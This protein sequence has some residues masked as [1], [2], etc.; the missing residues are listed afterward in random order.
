MFLG[1]RYEDTAKESTDFSKLFA[2]YEGIASTPYQGR[3][4][5]KPR[6]AFFTCEER[7]AFAQFVA[8]FRESLK[9]WQKYF[10]SR[11]PATFS[12]GRIMCMRDSGRK[13]S[14]A[15]EVLERAIEN[16]GGAPS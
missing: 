1:P 7:E 4:K 13:L 11:A 9:M 8:Y 16:V 5:K 3:A 10:L 2:G 12:F 15:I 6:H 14:K